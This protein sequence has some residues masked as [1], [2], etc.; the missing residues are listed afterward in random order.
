MMA[1]AQE[2]NRALLDKLTID[3][4]VRTEAFVDIPTDIYRVIYDFYHLL[5]VVLTFDDKLKSEDGITLS[6]DKL[7]AI[8]AEGHSYI[9]TTADP[10]FEG[11]HCWRILVKINIIMML[12][13]VRPRLIWAA[14]F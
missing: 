14:F 2:K 11:V 1:A 13:S 10:V 3:G 5:I 4:Y 8:G 6:E 9:L 12:S 7:C